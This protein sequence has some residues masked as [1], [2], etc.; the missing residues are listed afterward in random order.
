MKKLCIIIPTQNRPK[1]IAR[2]LQEAAQPAF[3]NHVDIVL[4]DTSRDD[5]T[6]SVAE[7]H[8]SHSYTSIIYNRYQ[9]ETDRDAIDRKVFSAC[10]EYCGDYDYIWF[11][12]DRTIVNVEAMLPKLKNFMRDD[13]DLIVYDNRESFGI[14]YQEYSDS[15]KLL[16]DC[17]WR[18]TCL[19]SVIVSCRFLKACIEKY[20]PD[21]GPITSFWLPMTYFRTLA[22]NTEG[23]L[24]AVW[25][26]EKESW[27]AN[28]CNA[29]A[30]WLLSGNVL[31]QW[32]EIWC[33]AMDSLPQFYDEER[34][35]VIRSHDRQ[36][37][38]FSKKSLLGLRSSGNVTLRKVH[39]NRKYLLRA[40][41]TSL[42]WFY[43][44]AMLVPQGVARVMRNVYHGLKNKK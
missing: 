32:G 6:K 15:R 9:G 2:Y 22:D 8:S 43:L 17:G 24:K 13:F 33:D 37:H 25:F 38:I 30:F 16:H 23:M 34:D 21:A 7:Q 11:S 14:S 35:F 31:R 42:L 29:E 40:S 10:K 26:V 4:Y 1:E 20:P 3:E 36:M 19:S 18:M 41:N 5:E 12:S 28:P 44:I 39:E 27:H